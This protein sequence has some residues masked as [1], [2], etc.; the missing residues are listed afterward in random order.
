[1]K[2]T[3]IACIP[4]YNEERTIARVVIEVERYVDKV[5]VCDD[6]STDLT[7]EIAGRL[8]AEV[9]RHEKNM[10][11][12]VALR[13]LFKLAKKYNPSIVVTIDA[14]GQHDP[15]DIPKLVEPLV[16][17]EADLTIG[18]RYVEGAETDAPLYRRFGLKI[19]NIFSRGV[20]R[21]TVKDTQSGFRAFTIK[22]LSEVEDFE[23]DGF[24]VESE[25]L[26]LALKRGLRVKEV[27]IN[28][29]YRGLPKTSKKSPLTHGGEIIS[30]ILKMVVEER[31]L[32][33]LGVPG[34]ILIISAIILGG[35]LLLT[36]NATRYFSLPTAIIMLG[37]SI[38]GITLTVTALTLYALNRIVERIRR[39]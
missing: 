27:P 25:Q 21:S 16:R 19:V 24:G 4:A 20:L 5:I 35:Y 38:I 39:K 29:R 2:P 37:A 1:M 23:S 7:G 22:A 11:K 3:I 32:L 15:N 8:G 33:Y 14:D 17:G 10:G 34:A 30:T 26:T 9:I 36:F 31:P 6:G 28:I 13:D 18:S 12:G